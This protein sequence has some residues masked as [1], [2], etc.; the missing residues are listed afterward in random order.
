MPT[1]EVTLDLFATEQVEK[2]RSRR[3]SR[4]RY[5]GE[6]DR[7]RSTLTSPD[8]PPAESL[9]PITE[10]IWLPAPAVAE[11][12]R[13]SLR[14]SPSL[15]L[16]RVIESALARGEWLKAVS[17]DGLRKVVEVDVNPAY[18]PQRRPGDSAI[19]NQCSWLGLCGMVPGSP[20][21]E[22]DRK[23]NTDVEGL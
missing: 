4:S 11:A 22:F 12:L 8:D 6:S 5:D 18:R 2:G 7:P 21:C 3:P 10:V 9:Q 13:R 17:V 19:C 23:E 16:A 15:S 14:F 1:V 20:V